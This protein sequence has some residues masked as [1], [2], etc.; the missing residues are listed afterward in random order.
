MDEVSVVPPAGY[1]LKK[2]LILLAAC[3]QTLRK[4]EQ[5]RLV[6]VRPTRFDARFS[7]FDPHDLGSRASFS[8][9]P[10]AL[11]VFPFHAIFRC[12][13]AVLAPLV[14][15]IAFDR[16]LPTHSSPEASALATDR[17]TMAG[18]KLVQQNE[19]NWNI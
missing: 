2:R 6:V 19:I 14:A 12:L 9:R 11:E 13:A 7:V 18:K 8:V 16:R 10:G 5:S 17:D 15:I 3:P 1:T 4:L